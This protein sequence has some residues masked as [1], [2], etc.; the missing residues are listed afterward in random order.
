MWLVTRHQDV[1]SKRCRENVPLD[2]NKIKI[3]WVFFVQN[4]YNTFCNN[5]GHYFFVIVYCLMLLDFE[6]KAEPCGT[7][8]MACHTLVHRFKTAW[9]SINAC[10]FHCFIVNTWK[11]KSSKMA[12]FACVTRNPENNPQSPRIGWILTQ[13]YREHLRFVRSNSRFVGKI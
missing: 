5:N 7:F 11:L 9:K 12:Y 6:I 3:L 4:L 13:V 8:A 10:K 1:A 2:K